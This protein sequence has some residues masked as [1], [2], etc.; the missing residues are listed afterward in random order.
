MTQ[1]LGSSERHT[2]GPGGPGDPNRGHAFGC[3]LTRVPVGPEGGR[4]DRTLLVCTAVALLASVVCAVVA[5]GACVTR[6]D[7]FA[8]RVVTIG[9]GLLRKATHLLRRKPAAPLS[10]AVFSTRPCSFARSALCSVRAASA[11]SFSACASMASSRRRF[12]RAN[13]SIDAPRDSPQSQPNIPFLIHASRGRSS[14][15]YARRV[16]RA[17]SYLYISA[18]RTHAINLSSFLFLDAVTRAVSPAHLM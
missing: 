15:Y 4:G 6:A 18:T 1:A 12:A 5:C 2:P 9:R 10:P 17:R 7:L 14:S 8:T 16:T 11:A 13:A 3:S